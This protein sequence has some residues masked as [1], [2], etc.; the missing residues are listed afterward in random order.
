LDRQSEHRLKLKT[1]FGILLLLAAGGGITAGLITYANKVDPPPQQAADV[2]SSATYP[3]I[4]G[5][6][7]DK[8]PAITTPAL[9]TNEPSPDQNSNSALITSSISPN[10]AA[11]RSLLSGKPFD[12]SLFNEPT[13]AATSDEAPQPP[14]S[15]TAIVKPGK[16]TN[17]LLN[18]AQIAHLKERLKLSSA[19]E[20][21]WPEI[22]AALR[23]VVKQIYEANKKARG[24]TVP[25]NTN[26]TEVE[27][28]KTAAIPLLMRLRPDQKTEVLMLARII[29]MDKMIATL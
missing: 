24:A 21:Y 1:I 12:G 18:D 14:P 27:R 2:R 13:P 11:D 3:V 6:K 25:I 29:G 5:I 19:Q 9:T 20:P 28:L 8:L 22:E 15:K 23:D 16:S 26:T 4:A 17:V 7:A 10:V